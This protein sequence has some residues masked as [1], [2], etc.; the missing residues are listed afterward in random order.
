MYD[1]ITGLN[2]PAPKPKPAAA[3]PAKDKSKAELRAQSEKEKVEVREWWAKL[4]ESKRQEIRNTK[5]WLDPP[6]PKKPPKEK[7][8]PKPKT[9]PPPAH[10]EE[11][12]EEYASVFD[13]NLI[14]RPIGKP[15]WVGYEYIQQLAIAQ[16]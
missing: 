7:P 6:K 15:D 1:Y 5:Y 4:D 11:K 16:M 12:K 14:D 8:K 13:C 9:K 2:Q 10:G 3:A